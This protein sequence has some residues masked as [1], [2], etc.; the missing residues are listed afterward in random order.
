MGEETSLRRSLHRELEAH[1]ESSRWQDALT[2]L[3]AL[4]ALEASAAVRA[5]YWY[6][7]ALV[8]EEKLEDRS[9][10]LPLFNQ[11]LD[12]APDMDDA[13]AGI[14]RASRATGDWRGL[15][16]NLH[17][18][19][20]RLP[21]GGRNQRRARL[22]NTLGEIAGD[23]L[24]DPATA[25]AA[26]EAA[27]ALEPGDANRE[28]RLAKLYLEVGPDRRAQ[29]IAAQ[30]RLVAR[31][32]G[33]ADPYR[34]L[35]RLYGEAGEETRR[36]WALAALVALGEADQA[37]KQSYERWRPSE[38][39]AAKGRIDEEL[40]QRLR[41]PDED[42]AASALF[43]LVGPHL[44]RRVARRHAAVGLDRTLRIKTGEKQ[45]GGPPSEWFTARAVRYAARTL[46]VAEPD[47]FYREEDPEPLTVSCLREGSALTPAL[48]AGGAFAKR[49]DAG[50]LFAIAGQVALL[51]PEWI[52]LC[53][54]PTRATIEI[55][56]RAAVALG[57]GGLADATD[58]GIADAEA[59]RLARRLRGEISPEIPEQLAVLARDF[60]SR[61]EPV[62]LD[63][64]AAAAELSIAR[65]ALLVSGDLVAAV[66]EL[67][68][69]KA[70]DGSL[71]VGERTKDLLAWAVSEDH[72]ALRA[73]LG[74][75]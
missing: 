45:L 19:L 49:A 20:G 1:A 43:G 60:A 2:T 72:L 35:A 18:M 55:V 30:H 51:R 74:L 8:H 38:P 52:L 71:P 64:W 58:V 31:T 67:S 34:T 12:L 46:D 75:P 56:Y 65:A 42:R 70:R 5:K 47:L 23:H 6:A 44:A 29:A 13:W 32:P 41:H 14:E 50:A 63:R 36:A 22:W 73:A 69:E 17:R 3:H 27:D 21:D 53:A 24:D 26:C 54:L 25:L 66:A 4:A 48:I 7:A 57:G 62:D 37:E 9:S 61:A 10:A 15:A 11:A 68:K 33:R 16:N 28:E 59:K 40:W 39:M